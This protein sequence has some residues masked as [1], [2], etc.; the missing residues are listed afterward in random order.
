MS[1]NC[2]SAIPTAVPCP[3][4]V[5][6]LLIRSGA[7]SG[8]EVV[9]GRGNIIGKY[10]AILCQS[11]HA[12][13]TVTLC[14]SRSTDID[15]H[16]RRADI[17]IAAMGMPEFEADMVKPGAVVI[18]VGVNT[19]LIPRPKTAAASWAMSTSAVQAIIA[20]HP[21]SRRRGPNDHRHA[22]AQHRPRRRPRQR[23]QP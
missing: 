22:A 4:G 2:L 15:E 5:H 18:D 7:Y 11:E 1:A 23:P 20:H 3:R 13:A 14:H 16:C 17:L 8:A 21:Q 6:E 9:L 10:G 19:S 12:N